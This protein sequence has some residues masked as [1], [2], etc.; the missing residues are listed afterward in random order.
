MRTV[1]GMHP[2]RFAVALLRFHRGTVRHTHKLQTDII[3]A[4]F[5]SGKRRYVQYSASA[6]PKSDEFCLSCIALFVELSEHLGCLVLSAEAATE[7]AVP[8]PKAILQRAR[9]APHDGTPSKLELK[10]AHKR[11]SAQHPQKRRKQQ[12]NQLPGWVLAVVCTD[13]T[14]VGWSVGKQP[15]MFSSNFS[16]PFPEQETQNATHFGHFALLIACYEL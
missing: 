11:C 8:T 5:Y 6:T 12:A 4:A 14:G 9:A 16:T 2:K 10:V 3:E 15:R 13:S 7:I 1:D